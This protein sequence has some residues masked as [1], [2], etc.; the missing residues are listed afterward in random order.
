MYKSAEIAGNMKKFFLS[1]SVILGFA[2]Y[3]I[4]QRFVVKV[5]ARLPSGDNKVRVGQSPALATPT[6]VPQNTPISTPT[7]TPT[8]TP[9]NKPARTPTNTPKPTLTLTSTP[10]PAPKPLG[11][12]RD[13]EYTG[14]VADAYYGNIQVKAIIQGGHITDVQFLDYPQDRS[15][16]REINSQATPY[17][18]TEA[19][20]AQNANV[21]IISG[22]TQTSYG[23]RES[24]ATALAQ[25]RI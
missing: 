1:V 3:V 16:S 7:K 19:I 10:T 25:A 18:K 12:Y 13:G 9:L 5:S 8:K 24:L 20:Q 14:N 2:F 23:F 17:L 4:H 6:D 22:A 15:T 11:P 21:D